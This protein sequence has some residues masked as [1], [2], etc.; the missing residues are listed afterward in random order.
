[1]NSRYRQMASILA[2]MQTIAVVPRGESSEATDALTNT[3]P[4]KL[5]QPPVPEV[6]VM[7][8]RRGLELPELLYDHALRNPPKPKALTPR[9]QRKGWK[10]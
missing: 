2:A 8:V 5:L 4:D 7:E 9:S 1:M 10:P 6:Y 3:G